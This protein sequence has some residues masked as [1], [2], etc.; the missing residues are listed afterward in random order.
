MVEVAVVEGFVN[1]IVF[2][3]LF[4]GDQVSLLGIRDHIRGILR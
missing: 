2:V 4:E 1:A 3:I